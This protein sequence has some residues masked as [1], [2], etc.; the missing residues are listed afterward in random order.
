MIRHSTKIAV[1][2][3]VGA[4]VVMAVLAVG[5]VW[6]LSSGPIQLDS[7]KPEVEAALRDEERGLSVSMQ[8]LVLA[9]NSQAKRPDLRALGLTVEDG[10]GQVVLDL[11]LAN[12]TLSVADLLKGRIAVSRID[13]VGVALDL[14]RRADGSLDLNAAR[15]FSVERSQPKESESV[16]DDILL[17]ELMARPGDGEERALAKLEQ[18]R[19]IG[20]RMTLL[21]EASG[22]VWRAPQ[23]F[24]DLRRT[25][26]GLSAN[27]RF[28]L[29]LGE[30]SSSFE[31]D[32]ALDRDASLIDAA[33]DF[34]DLRLPAIQEVLKREEL[35]LLSDLDLALSGSVVGQMT[36][37]GRLK[38]A[39]VELKSGPGAIALRD[40]GLERLPLRSLTLGAGFDLEEG[41]INLR[42]LE[43]ALGEAEEGPVLTAS[44][45]LTGVSHDLFRP[46]RDDLVIEG[47]FGLD[48]VTASDLALYWPPELADGA[49]DWVTENITAGR[50]RDLSGSL[51]LLAPE[52]DLNTLEL[53]SL[54][55]VFSYEGLEAHYLRPL[56]SI[57]GISGSAR[58]T[59][60]ALTFSAEGGQSGNIQVPDAQIAITGLQEEDQV[61]TI[62]TGAAGPVADIMA[63]LDGPGLELISRL[64]LAREGAAGQA[65]GRLYFSFPLINELVFEQ[66]DLRAEAD[67]TGAGLASV[68]LGQDLS[69]GNLKLA[70][71]GQEL[72]LY[73][74]GKL[75]G[76]PASFDWTEY[77]EPREGV[78]RR[79]EGNVPS[80]D[81]TGILQLGLDTDPYLKGP[82]A[83]AFDYRERTGARSSVQLTLDLERASLSVPV[84]LG[85][86][87]PA[88]EAGE[89]RVL[90]KLEKN[91][92]RSLTGIDIA[93][94]SLTLLGDAYFDEAGEE[95]GRA[96]IETLAFGDQSLWGVTLLQ[97]D[98]RFEL[99][100]K[101]G[102]LDVSPFLEIDQQAGPAARETAAPEEEDTSQFL[103]EV[104]SLEQVRFA[105]DRYLEK[106]SVRLERWRDGWRRAEVRGRIPES[107]RSPGAEGVD[108]RIDYLPS[109]G[110]G[111]VLSVTSGDAGGLFRAVNLLD[112]MEG[113]RLAI[114]GSRP[115]RSWNTPL[116]GRLLVDEFKLVDAPVLARILTLASFTGIVNVLSGDGITFDRIV[117][118][119]TAQRGKLSTE[120]MRAYGPAIG[121]TAEGFIDLDEDQADLEGTVVPAYS[122]NRVLGAIPLLGNILTGGEGEGLFAVTYAISGSL[123]A[124]DVS[125]NPLSVL[126]PGFLRNLFDIEGGESSGE[127]EP[128]TAVPQGGK[129]RD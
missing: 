13:V 114:S 111:Q 109:E 29:A 124:L 2:V 40:L 56:P 27:I 106:G 120:L 35:A 112:T 88:G 125:V 129:K 17:E 52:G 60:E 80:I 71:T 79:V 57:T 67:L 83:A 72:R 96:E 99:R 16:I 15:P 47:N 20:G 61:I 97:Q 128:F 31:M 84:L 66:V 82:V 37:R 113:G 23:A 100:A 78:V 41:R 93:A 75:G 42:E 1:E 121:L 58:F 127:D 74:D 63:L 91:V 46:Q 95:I 44:A 68:V 10:E 115:D 69:E 86:S 105:P 18:I 43:A 51:S 107:L 65:E 101:G 98:E 54:E 28:D 62:E 33:I 85:W 50:A 36:T 6:R 19:I 45:A 70:A 55:G 22:L 38:T 12:V 9:W 24:L 21:D 77:F 102:V 108:I 64:G 126:A 123:E 122:V 30:D 48:G 76:I 25:E 117:G 59:P 89:A 11:P 8:E 118:D 119:F 26:T 5:F 94:G 104:E 73:G 34:S 92:P 3:L 7:F 87:K 14:V 110:G 103:I 116:N 53:T 39:A 4:V 49:Y 90:L 32:L 81:E